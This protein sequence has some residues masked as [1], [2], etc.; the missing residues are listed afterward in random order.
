M[1]YNSH[2][3]QTHSYYFERLFP[4][5]FIRPW[6][7]FYYINNFSFNFWLKILFTLSFRLSDKLQVVQLIKLIEFPIK[8]KF[9][10]LF[11]MLKINSTLFIPLRGGSACCYNLHT[12][13]PTQ[14]ECD[15]ASLGT[16]SQRGRSDPHWAQYK[17]VTGLNWSRFNCQNKCSYVFS[18]FCSSSPKLSSHWSPIDLR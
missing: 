4:A 1:A 8:N 6:I 12:Y 16:F 17:L 14:Q 10:K 11:Y 15:R 18:C 9:K 7:S 13:I 3:N 2:Q 5:I